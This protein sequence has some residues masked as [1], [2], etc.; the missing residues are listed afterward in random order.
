MEWE[1]KN[2]NHPS[3]LRLVGLILLGLG[4]V[5]LAI[6]IAVTMTVGTVLATALM[7]SSILVN[8]LAVILLRKKR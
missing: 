2:S 5:L 8:T 7:A 1:N 4:V 3:T 6:A